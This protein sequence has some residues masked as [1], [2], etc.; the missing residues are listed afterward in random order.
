MQTV[1]TI[2]RSRSEIRSAEL[3]PNECLHKTK[4]CVYFRL[5]RS[6]KWTALFSLVRL[7]DSH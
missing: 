3:E 7:M 4:T 2:S 6:S 1:C 5:S